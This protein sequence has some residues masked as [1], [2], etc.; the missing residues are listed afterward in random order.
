MKFIWSEPEKYKTESGEELYF[1]KTFWEEPIFGWLRYH[2]VFFRDTFNRKQCVEITYNYAHHF[3]DFTMFE[4]LEGNPEH[5]RHSIEQF[6]KFLENSKL[7]YHC[8]GDTFYWLGG[9]QIPG[10][11]Y[12]IYAEKET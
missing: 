1:P 3:F 8:C 11:R 7:N 2:G 4:D 10:R 9:K 6:E 5:K 12:W